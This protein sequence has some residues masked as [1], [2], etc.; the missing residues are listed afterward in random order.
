[1]KGY[2]RVHSYATCKECDWDYTDIKGHNHKS[3]TGRRSQQHADKTGH[4]VV[5]EIGLYKRYNRRPNK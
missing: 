5:V 3:D 2:R 4:E 1:M